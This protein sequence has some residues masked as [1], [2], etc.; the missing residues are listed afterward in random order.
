MGGGRSF[1]FLIYRQD[2]EHD[3]DW[4]IRV[5]GLVELFGCHCKMRGCS[6]AVARWNGR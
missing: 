1:F 2:W 6:N 4:A 5:T 3:S